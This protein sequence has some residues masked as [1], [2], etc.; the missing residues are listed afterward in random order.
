MPNAS[1]S[2]PRKSPLRA[3]SGGAPGIIFRDEPLGS[4]PAVSGP[5]LRKMMIS[6]FCDSL[7]TRTNKKKLP[8]QEETITA[9]KI[10]ARALDAWMTAQEIKGDFTVCDTDMLNRFFADYLSS[11]GQTGT[12]TKQR[13]LRHLFTWLEQRYGHPH[14]YTDALNRY[15]ALKTRPSTLSVQFIADLLEITGNGRARNF[16]D[17]R[18]HALIRFLCEGVRRTEV[19]QLKMNDLSADLVARPFVRVTALK[20]ARSEEAGRMV[21]LSPA[22]ARAIVAYLRFR[23][24]H[25]QASSPFLWLGLRKSGPMDGWA[26]YRMLKRRAE[27]AGYDPDVHPHQFRHTFASDWRSK[28]GSEGDLMRLMGWRSR[29]MLDRY[30]ED[31]ADQRAFDAKAQMGDLY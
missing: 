18:D 23:R 28:G 10:A 14:P 2:R 16:A 21:P 27:Q 15:A 26:L 8:F 24:E 19:T 11:H 5:D 17:A 3:L 31:M 30:G 4:E 25:P 20:G 1:A 22:T 12:N 6:E 7:R 13:N 9:Y 29:A